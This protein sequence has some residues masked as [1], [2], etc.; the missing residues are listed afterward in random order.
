M[1]A[2]ADRKTPYFLKESLKEILGIRE[3]NIEKALLN[4][5]A[6]K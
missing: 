3:F 2:A 1:I 4:T 6:R 5:K